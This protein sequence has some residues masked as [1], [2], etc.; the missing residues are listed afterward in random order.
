LSLE[1]APKSLLFVTLDSCRYDTFAEVRPPN[2]S[3]IGR[4]HRAHAPGTFTYGS[5]AAMFVGFTPGV[6]TV[7]EPY[8]NPKF[9]RIFKMRSRGTKDAGTPWVMLGGRNVVEGF[10]T[11]GYRAIGSGGVNWFNPALPTSQALVGDFEEFYFSPR[12]PSVRRQIE[13]LSQH[14]RDAAPQQPLFVFLNVGETHVPYYFDGAP[15]SPDNNPCEPFGDANDAA[16]CRTRQSACLEFVDRELAPLLEAFAN[17]NVLV[18]ADHGDAWGEG[19]L[20]EHGIHHPQVLEVPLLLRL[21]HP[22]DAVA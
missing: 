5:H 8:V 21:P 18:C 2:L 12:P 11:L 10:R 16:E 6:F 19:G 20:W 17:A 13:F 22:P 3:R 4:L 15:W 14:I 7:R 1:V 9:A